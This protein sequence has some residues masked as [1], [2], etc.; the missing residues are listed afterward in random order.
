MSLDLTTPYLYSPESADEPLCEALAEYERA[1]ESAQRPDREAFLARHAALAGQLRPLL[2]AAERVEHWTGPLRR[3]LGGWPELPG[4]EILG[5]IG[6]GG[7]GVV[8]K[9]RQKGTE[10]IVALKMLLPDA[11]G[12]HGEA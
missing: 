4:Y 3:A 5:E 8:Y 12:G 9:A 1:L 10:Q 6:R 11:R 2:E 7:M